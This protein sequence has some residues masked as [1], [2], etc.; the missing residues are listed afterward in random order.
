[1]RK[2]MVFLDKSLEGKEWLV[3]DSITLADIVI[4]SFLTIHFM[5]RFDGTF[6]QTIPHASG[7]F[8]KMAA[9]EEIKTIYGKFNLCKK[10]Q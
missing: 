9:T 10:P 6:R 1:M 3:G 2:F 5:K 7:W 4:S 8:E